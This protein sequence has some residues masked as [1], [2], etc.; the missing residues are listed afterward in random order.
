MSVL[1]MHDKIKFLFS[2]YVRLFVNALKSA[3]NFLPE[4]NGFPPEIQV[5]LV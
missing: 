2:I 5:W 1:N 4:Y 3:L